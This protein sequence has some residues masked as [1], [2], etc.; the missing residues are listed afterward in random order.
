MLSFDMTTVA[1]LAMF[2]DALGKD[3]LATLAKILD[4]Q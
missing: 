3:D 4:R 2:I 1:L